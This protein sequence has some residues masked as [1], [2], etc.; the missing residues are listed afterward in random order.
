MKQ[1]SVFRISGRT[2][3]NMVVIESWAGEFVVA[4]GEGCHMDVSQPSV[5]PTFAVELNDRR[6]IITFLVLARPQYLVR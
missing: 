6:R 2:A 4:P 3:A 1:H 5:I